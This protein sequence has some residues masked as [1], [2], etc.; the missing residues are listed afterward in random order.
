MLTIAILLIAAGAIEF[1]GLG[2]YDAVQERFL[3]LLT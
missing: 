3:L 1:A 2:A